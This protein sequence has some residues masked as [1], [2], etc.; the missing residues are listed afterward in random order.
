MGERTYVC[1]DWVSH[2]NVM[3]ETFRNNSTTIGFC[4]IFGKFGLSLQSKLMLSHLVH[5]S[6]H[7]L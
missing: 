6:A 5:S 3:P 4:S 7:L 1:S 2:V